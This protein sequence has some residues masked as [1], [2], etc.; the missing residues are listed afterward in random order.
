MEDAL[1]E[2]QDKQLINQQHS[3]NPCSNGRCS[4]RI[5]RGLN[6]IDIKVLILVLMED[7]LRDFLEHLIWSV[8]TY[9]LNPCSNGRCSASGFF[10]IQKIGTSK[11]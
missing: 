6:S 1:R 4:A 2:R 11:S 9:S 7:A 3:L 5:A 8:I 10:L